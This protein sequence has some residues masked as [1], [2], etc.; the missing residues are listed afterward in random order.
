MRK[1]CAMHVCYL[2]EMLSNL[3]QSWKIAL[4]TELRKPYVADLFS[5]VETEYASNNCFPPKEQV[6]AALNEC[7]SDRVRV[8]IIGQ[9][10]Y[11]GAG[12]AHGLCFSVN[13][14][15]KHPPS[16][17]NIFREMENDLGREIPAS[18]NLT[19]WAK[20]GVLLLNATLTVREGEAGS[21]QRKGWEKL[22]DAII[23]TVSEQ[24]E[25]VVFMLWGGPAKKKGSKIDRSKHLV[26]E[27]G[28]PSPLS[29]NQ[30]LWFGNRHFSK[31]NQYLE[32]HGNLPIEW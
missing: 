24:K 31:A 5:F 21:H 3:D 28:H 22:T 27:S 17:R 20:Q 11:H 29:A 32:E 14:F 1:P 23:S 26:L 6:F 8:V 30:G 2:C 10:P 25:H 13:D 4:Y 12:Q 16:L 7:P 19:R 9:D 18:G 15:I